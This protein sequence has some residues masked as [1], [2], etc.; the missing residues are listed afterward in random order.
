MV[1]RDGLLTRR[2]CLLAAAVAAAGE[3][4]LAQP[5]RPPL[6][7]VGQ[8]EIGGLAPSSSGYV[9]SR[10]QIA[11]TLLDASPDGQPMPGLAARWS[12]SADGLLWKFSL[13]SGVRFHDGTPMNAAAVV[14]CL[15]A[16]RTPPAMLSVAPLQSIEAPD[17]STV[18]MRLASPF[19]G[20]ASLLS[21]SSTIVLAPSS[22]GVDGQ[23]R[24]I[25]ATGPYR[26][27]RLVPP[28][29]LEAIAFEGYDG[30]KPSIEKVNYLCAGRAETRALMAESGQ[31]DLAFGLD[32]ASLVRLQK[33]RGLRMESVTL[34][35]TALVK[36]NAGW[37]MLKDP[38]VR[39]AMSLALDRPGMATA[40]LRDPGLAAT[41]LFPPSLQAWHN[42]ALEPLR[43]DPAAAIRLLGEAGWRHTAD[44]LRNAR[45]EPF[46]LKLRTFPDRPELPL[47]AAALQEQWRQVGMEVQVSIGNSGDVPLGH[48]DGSLQLALLAR[49]YGTVP[50]LT[51][52]LVQDFGPAGGDWGAMGWKNEPFDQALDELR[53]GQVAPARVAPLRLTVGQL[54]HTDLPVIPV[55]WYRL[56]VAV[57]S[58]LTGVSLD[59]LE[60]SYRLTSMRWSL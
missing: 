5:D 9:F 28:Q 27:A 59:P 39:Q 42:T 6:R 18:V 38:R 7:I 24:Q 23:V 36:V 1:R 45:G 50:D 43:H 16:A 34:P 47:I 41:Q 19:A 33:K 53:R 60:R 8:W 48:R 46:Q 21:H 3:G 56:H 44:G 35:R 49:N 30:P 37:S 12:V 55:T 26:V 58:R 40:L 11:E 29:R 17:E 57:S 31:A 15:Q 51:G 14:R 20:L 52:T 32:P 25:V 22:F 4:V 2:Q 10:L 54:L 13:R